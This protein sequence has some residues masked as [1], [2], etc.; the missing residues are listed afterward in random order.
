MT[1]V[2]I[3]QMAESARDVL[4]RNDLGSWT[5]AAPQLYPHQWSWDSAF[6]AIGLAQI[7]TA[8]AAQE[9]R[10]LFG[11]QWANGMVPHIVFNPDVAVGSYFPDAAYWDCAALS[12]NVSPGYLTSGIMQP[13]VHAIAAWRI[14]EV[15]TTDDDRQTAESFLKEIAPK[16]LAWHRYLMTVRDPERSGLVTI[17]HPWESGL[18]NSPRWDSAMGR[19]EVGILPPYTRFD[20]QHVADPSQRPTNEEYNRYLWLVELLKA[21]R[22][23]DSRIQPHYPFLIKDVLLSAILVAANEA[24]LRIG[25]VAGLSPGERREVEEWV[26]RGRMGLDRAWDRDL[27]V[28]LDY[29]TRTGE[30]I[31]TQTI[32]GFAPFVAGG[33]DAEP[34]T[35]LIRILESDDFLGHP[36]L[37]WAVPPST[38]PHDSAFR[39]RSYWRGPTWPVITWLF[40]WALERAGERQLADRLRA[41]SLDQ[42]ATVGFA[43]YVEP[44]TGEPLGSLDQSWTAA[45]VLD[46]L[47][48]EPQLTT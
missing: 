42:I 44:F 17:Y 6:I 22:Y 9:I 43:E 40:W 16:L 45:V 38:S 5:K 32:A 19:V 34:R 24:L 48:A 29:D 26:V 27:G 23:D 11:A 31:R 47:G 14:R 15:A 35:A 1:A 7:D 8:R 41:A 37:R 10:T 46:W 2:D 25:D 33:L 12:A 20:L 3:E 4:R 21:A 28:C 36:D 30:P 18:D 13:P 39:P